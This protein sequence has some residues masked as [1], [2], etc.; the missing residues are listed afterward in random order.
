[1][2][3]PRKV[4]MVTGA[5][6]FI[7]S[8]LCEK[9][10]H[11]GNAVIGID[12]FTDYYSRDVKEKNIEKVKEN[13]NFTFQEKN[14]L[15]LDAIDKATEFIF[16]VA[17]QAGVRASW[18]RSFDVYIRE[19]ILATQHILELSKNH[20][21]L[22][23]IIYSSSSSIYGDAE[24]FP[25]PE[26][27]IP[28]PMSP[29]GVTKLAGEHLCQLYRENYGIPIISLRYFTVFGPR[30]R[31][32]MA[33]HKFIRA[34]LSGGTIEVYGDGKQSRDFTY[35][36]DVVWANLQAMGKLTEHSVFNIGGG[37]QATVNEVIDM[38]QE[39]IGKKAKIAYQEKAKGD[40]KNTKAD[41][42]RA[43]EELDFEPGFSLEDGLRREIEWIEA[44][45]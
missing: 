36:E 30:Q 12:C 22:R 23:K 15:D 5:A 27:S 20:R 44:N 41:I 40:V 32:D 24:S 45:F 31:P 3:N 1:M 2:K 26:D 14:I 38:L 7:G 25:T 43:K 28:K 19:N 6:G 17:A 4:V 42:S 21:N 9:L 11:E 8:H 37:N 10:L 35:I 33:F 16:H 13:A 18:G 29:Y 39:L 34:I